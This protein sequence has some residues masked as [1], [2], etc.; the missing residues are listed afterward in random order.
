MPALE[1]SAQTR[2]RSPLP[3]LYCPWQVTW[4]HLMSRVQGRVIPPG[5][6]KN[7]GESVDSLSDP[8]KES[9]KTPCVMGEAQ[10]HPPLLGGR[11]RDSLP[12]GLLP[13]STVS[14]APGRLSSPLG[15]SSTS[16]GAFQALPP[17]ESSWLGKRSSH[18]CAV[19]T[20]VAPPSAVQLP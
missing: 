6:Q 18:L 16:L 11:G 13:L 1:A 8:H 19:E 9:V 17:K 4:P 2:H 15:S 10:S 20:T 7:K 5:T 3:A 12:R 14:L